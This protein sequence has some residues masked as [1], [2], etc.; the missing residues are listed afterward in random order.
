MEVDRARQLK[1]D[2]LFMQ[3]EENPSTVN[4]FMTQIQELQDKVNSLIDARESM[5]LKLLWIITRSQSTDE[6]SQ[7]QRNDW[8]RFLL[9]A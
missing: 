3:Q 2:E 7:S 4:Q 5:I 8:P 9:A 1:L 6:Y